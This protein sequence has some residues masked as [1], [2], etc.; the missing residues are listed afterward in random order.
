MAGICGPAGATTMGK[1][2]LAANGSINWPHFARSGGVSEWHFQRDHDW[3][4]IK[5]LRVQK[6]AK[7]DQVAWFPSPQG[8]LGTGR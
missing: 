8:T 1:D 5:W 6:G 3:R 4:I 2:K 7:G